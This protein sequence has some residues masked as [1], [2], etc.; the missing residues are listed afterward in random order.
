MF[1]ELQTV[2]D[3]YAKSIVC[4]TEIENGG[5]VKVDGLASMSLV[6]VDLGGETFKGAKLTDE[7]GD[8]YAVVA[9]DVTEAQRYTLF[10]KNEDDMVIP[11][12]EPSRCYFFHTGMR[13]R[14]EKDIIAGNIAEGDKLTVKAGSNQ[15]QKATLSGETPSVNVVARVLKVTN[16]KGRPCYEIL[17]V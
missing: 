10:G 2:N 15:L 16:Y 12:N 1:L 3:S 6:G 17:F 13:L 14:V 8:L 4:D 5:I 11:A 7:L 9:P